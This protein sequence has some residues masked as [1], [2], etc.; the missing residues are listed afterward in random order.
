MAAAKSLVRFFL[1]SLYFSSDY[2]PETSDDR[3]SIVPCTLYRCA[4]RQCSSD[5]IL[6]NKT[7]NHS[8]LRYSAASIKVSGQQWLVS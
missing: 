6:A 1:T 8:R 4:G 3:R 7:K 2:L 5:G